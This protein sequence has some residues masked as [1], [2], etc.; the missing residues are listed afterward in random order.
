MDPFVH[1][2]LLGVDPNHSAKKEWIA[3]APRGHRSKTDDCP[4]RFAH[5]GDCRSAR[6]TPKLFLP[7][8]PFYPGMSRGC[9]ISNDEPT[10]L[11]RNP[12]S[13]KHTNVRIGVVTFDV[14][15]R[16]WNEISSSPYPAMRPLKQE[17]LLMIGCSANTAIPDTASVATP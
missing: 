14:T 17:R 1:V 16:P 10:V 8:C 12:Y 9:P 13:V 7:G 3:S 11:G 4:S 5:M 2:T 15:S 6:H